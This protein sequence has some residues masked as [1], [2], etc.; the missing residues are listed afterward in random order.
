M[1]I[2][3]LII[4]S[5]SD[6]IC[7]RSFKE[8]HK[9]FLVTI[10]NLLKL[11]PQLK[12]SCGDG[13]DCVGGDDGDGEVGVVGADDG[14]GE[15]GV[16]SD[17]GDV[18]GDVAGADGGDVG[19]YSNGQETAFQLPFQLQQSRSNNR[20]QEKSHQHCFAFICFSGHFSGQGRTSQKLD[21]KMVYC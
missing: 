5:S 2:T 20:R 3:I 13:D 18:G 16:C 10:L 4:T 14:D 7:N 8:D 21:D 11:Q 19:A 1:I 12:S 17:N 9:H 15:V 6:S